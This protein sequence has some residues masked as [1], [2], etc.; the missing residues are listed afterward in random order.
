MK[1]TANRSI[2]T[3][4]NGDILFADGNRYVFTGLVDGRAQLRGLRGA[5]LQLVVD[6]RGRFVL[7]HNRQRTVVSV[8]GVNV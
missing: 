1:R 5:A 7:V 8:V 2:P 4:S 3:M 6:A